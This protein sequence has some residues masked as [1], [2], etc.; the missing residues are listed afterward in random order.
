MN[1]GLKDDEF[2]VQFENGTLPLESFHHADHVKMAFL[3]LQ[4]YP[5]VEA[6]RRFSDA[7]AKFAVAHGKTGLY[8]ETITW[9]YLL[10]IRERLVRAGRQLTWMEFAS[11]NQD[12][13]SWKDSV[14]KKYYR[15]ET[16]TSDLA[17]TT[18]V[19]PD[20]GIPCSDATPS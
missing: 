18:F 15:E 9:A 13:L 19:L 20:R 17:R 5:I 11:G 8:N 6:L 1:E 7:L 12:L 4:K 16:L 2:V 3:Y 14:L 10:I